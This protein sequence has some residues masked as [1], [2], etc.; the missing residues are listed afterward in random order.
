MGST[1]SAVGATVLGVRAMTGEAPT[2]FPQRPVYPPVDL[3]RC[4]ACG[5]VGLPIV[6]DPGETQY[7]ARCIECGFEGRFPERT[8]AASR[9]RR[10]I[11]KES[12]RW[13]ERRWREESELGPGRA[14][15][16]AEDGGSSGG[17]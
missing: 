17:S 13:Q 15:Y 2:L 4:P 16:G 5:R 6:T 1:S 3:H 7:W 11:A 9:V 10:W 12:R 14:E 8:P